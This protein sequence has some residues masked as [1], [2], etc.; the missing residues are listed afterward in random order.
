MYFG[1]NE[2]IVNR[3]TLVASVIALLSSAMLWHEQIYPYSMVVD[4]LVG[5]ALAGA[6]ILRHRLG[7]H[8]RMGVITISGLLAGITAIFQTPLYANGYL[9]LAAVML[10][11]FASW[12][13]WLA[14]V[15][16]LLAVFDVL[17]A[18]LLV[19]LG[20]LE[21]TPDTSVSQNSVAIWMITALTIALL[22][23]GISG[24]INDLKQRLQMQLDHLQQTNERLFLAAYTDPITGLG[25]RH[26]MENIIKRALAEQQ[27][28]I[29]LFVDLINFRRF[30]ALNG[31]TQGDDVLKQIGEFMQQLAPQT[32]VVSTSQGGLFGIW[33]PQQ[34]LSQALAFYRRLSEGF[35]TRYTLNNGLTFH[36]GLVEAPQ[37]GH[38]VT[39]LFR[40]A[41]TALDVAKHNGALECMVFTPA[42]AEAFKANNELKLAVRHAL[43]N[44]HFYPVYQT[45]INSQTGQVCGAEGLARMQCT[46][47]QRAPGHAAFIP[48]I[49]AEGW[50][51]EFGEVMLNA[52]IADIP[53]LMV[54]FGTDTKI[55]INVSPPLFLAPEFLPMF[56]ASLKKHAVQ[57]RNVIIEITEEVF[58]ANMRDVITVTT[59][60]QQL[61][62]E[63][64]LDDFGA[65]FSSLS[66][67]REVNFNEIKID[68]SF[69]THIED[70]EKSKI[71]LSAITKL[72]LTLGSRMVTE[73]VETQAQLE[74]VQNAGC[75]IIQGYFY[76]K[77]KPIAELS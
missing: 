49:H 63:V 62:A 5:L 35:R 8:I 74:I 2:R 33:M 58:A 50:M 61:G 45:K 52:I 57:P 36:A 1:L 75:D 43:D 15:L 22:A 59:Q 9:V 76:S 60:I 51:T 4:F 11:S 42:M 17:V 46:T 68:R 67:L 56:N 18:A 40:N 53:R 55:S 37:H 30:N 64:S 7:S 12:S 25:N 10:M 41:A 47:L 65:G 32:N 69:V 3:I 66:Y 20:Y 28:G 77:P 39:E 13:G 54:L 24:I 16:P 14:W 38:N 29:L 71:L 73:G 6:F 70:D 27:H 23:L 21:I 34:T 31:H 19:G 72:G 44:G 48:V 26:R